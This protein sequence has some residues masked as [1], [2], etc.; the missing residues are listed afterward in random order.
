MLTNMTWGNVDVTVLTAMPLY[1][2]WL[3]NLTPYDT[4]LLA[5]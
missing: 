2:A 3:M 4:P 5:K 1:C